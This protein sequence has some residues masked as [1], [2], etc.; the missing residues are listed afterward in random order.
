MKP[1]KNNF[2]NCMITDLN[3]IKKLGQVNEKANFREKT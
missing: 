1:Q 3:T 2:D